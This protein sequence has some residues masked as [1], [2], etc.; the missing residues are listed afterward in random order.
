MRVEGKS[1]IEA[2]RQLADM[3]GVQ[4]PT[5]ARQQRHRRPADRAR[6]GL[7]DPPRRR[8]ALPRDPPH[9]RR[10]PARPPLSTEARHH[11]RDRRGLPARLR[12]R[13]RRGRLGPPHPPPPVAKRLSLPLAEKL[14][15]VA[16]SERTD[17]YYDKFRGRLMFPV[18]QPGGTVIAFSGRV[19]PEYA[20]E[21]GREVDAPKYMN[22]PESM[23]YTKGKTL[24]GLHLAGQ[25]MRRANRAI[26]VEGNVDVVAM[27]QRGHPRPSPPSAP[28]S[29]PPRS[30]SSPASPTRSSS[31]STAT[32][33]AARRPARPSRCSST[34]A[35]TPASSR[36]TTAPTPTPPTPSASRPCSSSPAR[37]SSGTCARW[38]P[39]APATAST[40]RTARSARWP[41]CWP[42]SSAMERDSSTST[43]PQNCLVSRPGAYRPR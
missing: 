18:V 20:H 3:F 21:E 17:N 22:S 12:A 28:P 35:S 40:P 41:P 25:P 1:F 10:G 27:H 34:P 39:P 31:A 33:P 38:S 30:P 23:L 4:L 42:G 6:R 13:P 24:F 9:R 11:P 26:L 7:R 14:G 15:L 32:T 37:P 43:A 29:P 5:P 16:R 2:A 19:L 8:R 36:S